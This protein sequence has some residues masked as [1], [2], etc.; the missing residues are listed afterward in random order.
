MWRYHSTLFYMGE[1]RLRTSIRKLRI[2]FGLKIYDP[3]LS[4]YVSFDK[5]FDMTF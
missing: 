1:N 5:H 3:V 4:N 2:L